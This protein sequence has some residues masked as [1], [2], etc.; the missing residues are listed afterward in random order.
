MTKSRDDLDS[1]VSLK[2]NDAII[3]RQEN[4]IYLRQI[5][6]FNHFQLIQNVDTTITNSKDKIRLALIS[7][8]QYVT[9]QA[10]NAYVASIC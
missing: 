4:N 9:Q 10:R 5:S 8:E 7:K 6:Q 1:N 2:F 3:E